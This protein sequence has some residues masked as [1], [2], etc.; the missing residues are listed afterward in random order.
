MNFIFIVKE[1]ILYELSTLKFI[2]KC[3]MAM[4]MIYL[5]IVPCELKKNVYSALLSGSIL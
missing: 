1:H 3:F 4:H 2:E 5:G